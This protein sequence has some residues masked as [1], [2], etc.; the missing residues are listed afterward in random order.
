MSLLTLLTVASS[1]AFIVYGIFC[2]FT[3]SMVA[4]FHRFGLENLRVL[5]GILEIVGGTGLL[6]GFKWRPALWLSAAGLSLLMLIAFGVRLK[7]R[8]S[9]AESIPSLMLMLI[10]LYICVQALRS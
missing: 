7:M 6:I 5:T 10:N 8:D 4:D 3:P 1:L 2:A 9:V